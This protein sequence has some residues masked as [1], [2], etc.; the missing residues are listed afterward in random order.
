VYQDFVNNFGPISF[1][2]TFSDYDQEI[3]TELHQEMRSRLRIGLIETGTDRSHQSHRV[4]RL[5]RFSRIKQ[6]PE[7]RKSSAGL[8]C[9]H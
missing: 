4:S 3:C 7:K 2:I 6:R 5:S 1:P 8:D 9:N